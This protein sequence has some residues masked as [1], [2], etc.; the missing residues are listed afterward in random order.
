MGIF[1][2]VCQSL[3]EEKLV[4]VTVTSTCTAVCNALLGCCTETVSPL[5]LLS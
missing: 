4:V 1:G 5:S 3:V 2:C